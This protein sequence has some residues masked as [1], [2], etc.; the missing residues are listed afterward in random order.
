M[1]LTDLIEK[2]LEWIFSPI[3]NVLMKRVRRMGG[4]MRTGG[5]HVRPPS[6]EEIAPMLIWQVE[7]VQLVCG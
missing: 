4:E 5:A 1:G 6:S 2:L 3:M 7:D